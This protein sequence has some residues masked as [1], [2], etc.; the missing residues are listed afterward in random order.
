[1]RDAG[2]LPGVHGAVNRRGGADRSAAAGDG[3]PLAFA[4]TPHPMR[5]AS[6]LLLSISAACA[7]AACAR[8]ARA[9]AA[10]PVVAAAS[11]ETR[12]AQGERPLAAVA[13]QRVVV[14]PVQ[15]V[16]GDTLGW[17]RA[18]SADYRETLDDEIAFA[19]GERVPGRGWVFGPAVVRNAARN[20]PH[21]GEPR[22]LSV[23]LLEKARRTPEDPVAEPLASQLRTLVALGGGRFALVPVEARFEPAAA[24]ATSGA[25]LALDLALVDAR[26]A[27]LLWSGTVRGDAASTFS[28][29]LAA[30]V[31]ARVADL[32]AA[33]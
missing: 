26:T 5:P 13:S 21:A 12:S 24:G 7:A 3:R 15:S 18:M 22:G 28:P 6:A 20:Q 31:A 2:K 29:A 33:R 27:R 23:P 10:T 11:G 25:R 4:R 1:M 32:I 8:A 30:G 16:R 17:L 9:E 19:I 14:M